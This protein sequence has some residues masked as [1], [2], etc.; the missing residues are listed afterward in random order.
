MFIA[1]Q[2]FVGFDYVFF[3]LAPLI[4]ENVSYQNLFPQHTQLCFTV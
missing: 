1:V 3:K 2:L 4:T